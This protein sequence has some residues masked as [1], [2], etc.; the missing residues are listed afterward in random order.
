MIIKRTGGLG[1]KGISR[2]SIVYISQNTE[3]SPGDLRRLAVTKTPAENHQLRLAWKTLK[4]ENNNDN[5]NDNWVGKAIQRELCKKL[6]FDH[7]NK[8][9]MHNPESVLENKTARWPDLAINKVSKI[10]SL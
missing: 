6:K 2:D 4:R 10:V 8:W 3:K 9:H 1:E 5:N 7:T